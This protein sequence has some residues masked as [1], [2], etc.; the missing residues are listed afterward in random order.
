MPNASFNIQLQGFPAANRDAVVSLVSEATGQRIER[1]PFLDGSLL[2]RDL[3]PGFYELEVRHPNL[4]SAIDKRRIRLFPQVPPTKVTVL[5]PPDLFRDTPIRDIPDIDLT[6]IRQAASAAKD[7]LTP[8]AG[9]IAGEA[10]KA[11]DWNTLV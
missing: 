11:S 9:K 3:N 2:V 7:S 6:P 8:L 1:K 4:I 10:I 5:V